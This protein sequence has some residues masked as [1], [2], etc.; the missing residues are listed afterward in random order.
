MTELEQQVKLSRMLA[1]GFVFT[2]ALPIVGSLMAVILGWKGRR[3]I[4]ASEGRLCG[5]TIAWWCILFGALGTLRA[6]IAIIT[7]ASMSYSNVK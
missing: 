6:L 1:M 3:V 7:W 5:R 2:I 4:Q